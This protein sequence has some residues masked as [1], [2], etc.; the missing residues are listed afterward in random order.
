MI[1]FL[2]KN[3]RVSL[4]VIASVSEAIPNCRGY[5]FNTTPVDL[6]GNFCS[7]VEVMTG[8]TRSSA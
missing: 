7:K 4:I 8:V 5:L 3:E 6:V 2:N 1:R